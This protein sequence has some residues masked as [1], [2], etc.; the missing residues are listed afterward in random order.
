MINKSYDLI[1]FDW[2]GTL[3]DTLGEILYC[4]QQEAARLNFGELDE[5]LARQSVDLGLVNAVKKVYPHLRTSQHEQ[6]LDAVQYA[7]MSRH[8]DI[9]LIPGAKEF[10]KRIAEQN[11]SLAI[12]TNK[13]NQGLQRALSLSGLSAFFK[14]TRCAGQ[15]APKPNPEM[16]QQILDSLNVSADKAL[17]IGDSVT[18]IEMA[19]SIDMDAIGV[20]FYQRDTS[21]LLAAGAI[22]VFD[23]YTALA[24]HFHLLD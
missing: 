24:N 4:V 16:L 13:G 2:E 18:D 11:I 21:G 23:N 17:M 6:L 5:Q 10:V 12:A 14:V 19:K 9:Y 3:S 22:V 7:L 20:D 1:I 15:T 8:N